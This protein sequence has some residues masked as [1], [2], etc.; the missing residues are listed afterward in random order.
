[1]AEISAS[2]EIGHRWAGLGVVYL[3]LVV[4]AAAFQVVPPV[5]PLLVSELGMQRSEIGLLMSCFALPGIL[6][7]IP[8]G[9]L[10]DRFGVRLVGTIGLLIMAAGTVGTG[11]SRSVFWLLACRIVAGGGGMVAVVALQRTITCLFQGRPLGLPMGVT[12][13]AIPV[14]IVVTLNV[15]GPAAEAVGWRPVFLAAGGLGLLTAAV[16]WIRCTVLDV[17]ST[18]SAPAAGGP[19]PNWRPIWIAGLV[20]LCA[21]GAMTTF[22]TFA[23]DLYLTRGLDTAARGILTSLP[24]LCAALLGPLVGW[25]TD[26]RGGKRILIAAGLA[27]LAVALAAVPHAGLAPLATSLG[28]G[29][30]LACIPTPL[31]SL[32][33][34]LLSPAHHGRAFGIL[35]ACA[36]LG[37]FLLPPL[38]GQARDTSGTYLISFLL[39]SGVAAA[40]ALAARWLPA[41]ATRR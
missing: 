7:S 10:A 17:R 15:A 36:N 37:I 22:V 4:F 5:V 26:R 32:P 39:A 27:S 34:D 20:W 2:T 9:L 16:F 40:G 33:A 1:M 6:L 31:M 21:N 28:L 14:G 24:M 35:A 38:A 12:N 29:L 30:A 41:G 3:A 18:E 25:Y 8:A 13:T 11:F 19:A 23:P